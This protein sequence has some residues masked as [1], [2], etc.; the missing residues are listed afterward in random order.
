MKQ[1][2]YTKNLSL[3]WCQVILDAVAD[4]GASHVFMSPGYRDAPFAAVLQEHPRLTTVSCMDE[5]ASGYMALG[6]AKAH[7]RPAVLICT[8]G[9]AVANYLPAVIEAHKESIPLIVLSCDR[10]IE[11]IHSGANQT[12]DQSQVLGAFLK[13]YLGLPSPEDQ[14]SAPTLRAMLTRSLEQGLIFPRGVVHI[15]VPLRAPLE[16]QEYKT[17][18]SQAFINSMASLRPTIIEGQSTREPKGKVGR[19]ED[20]IHRAERGLI[21]LGRL[22]ESADRVAIEELVRGLSWPCLAD[23]GSSFKGHLDNLVDAELPQTQEWLETYQPDAVLHLGRHLVSKYWDIYLQKRPNLPYVVVSPEAGSQNPAFTAYTHIRSEDYQFLDGLALPEQK[24][25]TEGMRAWM[26]NASELVAR[27]PHLTLPGLAQLIM[28]HSH[29]Q[30]LFLG[31][32][33]SIRAFD[34]WYFDS[35]QHVK[36]VDA[37][38]GASGIEGLVSTATG[39]AL[40]SGEAWDVVLG[41]VSM[42]HDLNSLFQLSIS[43]APLRVFLVNNNGGQIFRKLPLGQFPS[44]LNPLVTTPHE[45]NFQGVAQSAGLAYKVVET[46]D[47]LLALL[48]KA[49]RAPELIEVPVKIEDDLELFDAIKTLPRRKVL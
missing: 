33:S 1:A 10:P 48:Q 28:K 38:R 39:L 44:V 45:F 6:A 26:E 29:S 4:T 49:P 2:N 24:S 21:I 12:I 31:N 40:A 37:N 42:I 27:Y 35:P 15:N 36:R 30:N 41:D 18:R 14:I 13:D 23:I 3:A 5:R 11:L 20:L 46:K 25:A 17:D 34:T 9:T 43:P 7:Q 22:D 19:L 47:A 32:S 8:S 16:P